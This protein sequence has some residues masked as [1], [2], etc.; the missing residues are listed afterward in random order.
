M[1]SSSNGLETKI[2]LD[3]EDVINLGKNFR[4]LGML[5]YDDGY[6]KKEIPFVM[7][8]IWKEKKYIDINQNPANIPFRDCTS[9]SLILY[10][11]HYYNL[12]TKKPVKKTHHGLGKVLICSA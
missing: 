6:V 8:F 2:K 11:P 9:F 12:I 7:K 4:P 10:K 5:C 3:R 1:K